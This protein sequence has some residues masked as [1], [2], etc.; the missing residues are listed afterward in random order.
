MH[1]D[2]L[3]TEVDLRVYEE[4]QRCIPLIFLT[5]FSSIC[6]HIFSSPLTLTL[7]FQIHV[8]KKRQEFQ[9]E[10]YAIIYKNYTKL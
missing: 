5:S 8:A 7:A 1:S 4:S 10:A 9:V 6:P 2:Q 3:C